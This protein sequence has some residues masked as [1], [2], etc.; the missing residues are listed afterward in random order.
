L[1]EEMRQFENRKEIEQLYQKQL[2][3]DK[4]KK[5]L[6]VS[7]TLGSCTIVCS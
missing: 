4:K 7:S 2:E 6:Q 1:E 5:K 3:I